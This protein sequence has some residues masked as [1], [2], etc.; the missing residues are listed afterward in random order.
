MKIRPSIFSVVRESGAKA[1]TL[2]IPVTLSE[3]FKMGIGLELDPSHFF[4]AEEQRYSLLE[5]VPRGLEMGTDK[6][7]SYAQSM[8][9]VF[10]KEGQK[11]LAGSDP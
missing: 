3:E 8:K 6:L 11:V 9:L 4:K 2:S 5:S 1:D 10:T 7:T